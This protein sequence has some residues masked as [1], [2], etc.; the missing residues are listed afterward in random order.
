VTTRDGRRIAARVDEP[1]GD[2]GNTLS[3]DE[4]E[5]KARRLGAYRAGASDAEM[6]RIIDTVWGMGD[7]ALVG[8][9]LP[10]AGAMREA[11]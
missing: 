5:D 2:P 11:A 1:K 7:L 3:R 9:L 10:A 4:L 8:D 6:R